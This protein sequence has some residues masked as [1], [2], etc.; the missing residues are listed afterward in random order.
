MGA[1]SRN[2]EL[3]ESINRLLDAER[4]SGITLTAT[5]N[6]AL[7]WYFNRLEAPQREL[8]RTECAEWTRT[9]KIPSGVIATEMEK[10]LRTARERGLQQARRSS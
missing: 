10:A 6:A 3:D 9:G 2:L 7:Y 1:T 4:D 5:M 8:A